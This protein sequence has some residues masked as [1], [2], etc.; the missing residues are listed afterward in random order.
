MRIRGAS[1]PALCPGQRL[2]DLAGAAEYLHYSVYTVQKLRAAGTLRAVKLPGVHGIRFD[3]ND[4]AQL[5][6]A[7]KA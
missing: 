5:V 4:L 3:L 6:E 7:S 1:V 2:V